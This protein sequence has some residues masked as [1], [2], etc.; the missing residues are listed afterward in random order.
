MKVTETKNEGLLRE[1]KVVVLAKDISKK[2][3]DRLSK[4]A[5]TVKMAGFRPGKVPL[6]IVKKKHGKDVLGDVLQH[7]VADSS[8]KI[9]DERDLS[10]AL[11]PKIE[12]S[13]FD[14]GKNLEYSLSVEIYPEV[15]KID[16]SK[17]SLERSVVD[18]TEKDIKDGLGRLKTSR[19]DFVALEKARAA[20]KGDVVVIDFEGSIDGTLF[21]GGAGKDFRL[22]LGSSQ[23]IP[24]FEDQLVGVKKDGKKDVKV[25]F[26]ENYGSAD[27]AG[28]DAV[29]KVTVNDILE[30]KEPEINEEFATGLGFEDVAKLK[31][32]IKEQIEKDY[33]VITKTKLKKELF[34]KLEEVCKFEVPAGML[35]M[36]L[37]S[38]NKAV[39]AD[40]AEEKAKKP[41][42]K[43]KGEFEKLSQRRVR[44]GILLADLSKK[45]AVAVT[46]D[47]IRNAVFEQA[48]NYPGQEQKIIE[49]YQ[50][51]S[52]ALD[53][54]RGPILE[55]K[56]V[57]IIIGK[58]KITDKKTPIKD[59]LKFEESFE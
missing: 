57:D 41:T 19:R 16:F 27:L 33:S 52:Q 20:K 44:L 58:I 55:D 56:V 25:Q 47:E 39:E 6:S 32:A 31:D 21:D 51:N 35:Q 34:D 49:I 11:E 45:N 18:V 36:E 48:R 28:K 15:P 26:P 17:I 13:S 54:L 7:V 1:F 30:G 42:K 4:L 50:N 3:D 23:F 40:S 12:V 5:K 46:E 22:E 43:E 14:E 38:L 29:F 59:L 24:G 10:P 8:Q 37:D 53:G 2:V 9:M